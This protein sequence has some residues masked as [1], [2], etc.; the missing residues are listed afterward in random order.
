MRFFESDRLSSPLLTD[1][2]LN[3]LFAEY[4]NIAIEYETLCI[5]LVALINLFKEKPK[6]N[7]PLNR[8]DFTLQL[9]SK[10]LQEAKALNL[11][12]KKIYRYTGMHEVELFK[13]NKHFTEF[14]KIEAAPKTITSV[15][16]KDKNATANA[17]K[18]TFWQRFWAALTLQNFLNWLKSS[19]AFITKHNLH[20]LFIARLRRYLLNASALAEALTTN[21]KLYSEYLHYVDNYFLGPV[22]AYLSWLFLLPRLL[23]NIFLTLWHTI[24]HHHLGDEERKI[25]WHKRFIIQLRDRWRE[26]ANDLIWIPGSIMICF[27]LLGSL[28]TIGLALGTAMF[29]WDSLIAII[30][31]ATKISRVNYI[32]QQHTARLEA[33]KLDPVNRAELI[34][35]IE[36]LKKLRTH[37]IKQHT[38]NIANRITITLLS[39]VIVP[40]FFVLPLYIPVIA[41]TLLLCLSI[42]IYYI[43]EKFRAERP[44]AKF[45]NLDLKTYSE[46]KNIYSLG[47]QRKGSLEVEFSAVNRDFNASP[48]AKRDNNE[49]SEPSPITTPERCQSVYFF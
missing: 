48:Y 32:I 4:P 9:I 3:I 47:L 6:E 39:L 35:Y 1:E 13:L 16:N 14:R 8:L 7:E 45:D 5:R 21:A 15:K 11:L 49:G 2:E 27:F 46:F 44:E 17:N 30:E 43:N 20:R 24:N 33:N 37:E 31:G 19:R 22:V 12:L 42:A 34:D 40:A 36:E 41:S 10:A 25:S 28:T 38:L 26:F 18:K 29:A 23:I